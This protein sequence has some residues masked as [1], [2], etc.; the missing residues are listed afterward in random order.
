MLGEPPFRLST[1]AYL[2]S[3]VSTQSDLN[4]ASLEQGALP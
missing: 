1:I 4:P 3:P 2:I